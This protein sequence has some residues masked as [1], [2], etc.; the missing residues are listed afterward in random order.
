M[1]ALAASLAVEVRLWQV[2]GWL[3][4]C[5]GLT[6]R[7]DYGTPWCVLCEACWSACCSEWEEEWETGFLPEVRFQGGAL[8][9]AADKGDIDD[10]PV[11]DG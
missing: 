5:E 1:Q 6:K 3:V 9:R 2:V 7:S 8:V 4:V 11:E 10:P